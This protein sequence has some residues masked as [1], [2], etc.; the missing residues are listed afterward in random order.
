MGIKIIFDNGGGI[1]L[2]VISNDGYH[3]Q[4]WYNSPAYAANDA[5]LA[6]IGDDVSKWEGN[7]V[8]SHG[9]LSPTNDQ[10]ASGGYRVVMIEDLIGANYNYIS[11]HAAMEFT[12][13]LNQ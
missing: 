13:Y 4:H 10:I 11:G 12:K 6:F 9:W 5:L 3:Y 2:Q 7:D 8:D 1:T